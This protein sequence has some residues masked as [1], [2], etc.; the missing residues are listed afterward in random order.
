MFNKKNKV[1]PI[2][3]N[4]LGF[5]KHEFS[6]G[7]RICDK[8]FNS[9]GITVNEL[10]E[11]GQTNIPIDEL[12]ERVNAYRE[13]VDKTEKFVITKQIG[14]FVAFDENQ[15]K[16]ALLSSFKGEIKQTYNYSDVINFELL[17]DGNSVAS[18]GLGRALVGGVL[19]GG[20][21]AIVGGVTGKKTSK[22][23]CSS[24]KLK[25]TVNDMA[26]PVVYINFIETKL[27]TDGFAYRTFAESAQECLSTF[28]LICDRFS[29]EKTVKPSS[30][31]AD[32]IMK[33]KNLLDA[34]AITEE[35]YNI[36]KKELLGI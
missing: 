11:R 9:S 29:E 24:L 36:K 18:G 4:K 17:E 2:C 20:V 34:G 32:E 7:V 23:I 12:E 30:D 13:V 21:G 28:Q 26:N 14:N 35:E 16:W 8:C 27:K 3:D 5:F 10:L 19:F 6:G 1:C 15:Q 22:G 25:V 33:F 31:T